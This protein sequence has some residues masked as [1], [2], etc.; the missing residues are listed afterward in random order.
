MVKLCAMNIHP[1]SEVESGSRFECG[2]EMALA[3]ADCVPWEYPQVK[4]RLACSSH[5]QIFLCS[6]K[7]QVE[8]Q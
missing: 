5:N 7:E 6:S 2:L 8:R 4:S 1:I 3:G